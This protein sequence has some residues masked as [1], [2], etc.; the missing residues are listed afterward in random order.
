MT[1]I[2]SRTFLI[3]VVTSSVTFWQGANAIGG[4]LVSWDSASSLINTTNYTGLG[5]YYWFA[6]FNN[7]TPSPTPV[8]LTVGAPLDDH[9]ARNL[10]AWIRVESRSAFIGKDDSGLNSDTTIR[11]GFSFEESANGSSK[12][13]GGQSNFNV[14]TLPDGATGLSGQVF[15]PIP[16]LAT[17]ASMAQ[18][19]ILPGAPTSFRLWVITDNGA[20]ANFQSEARLRVRHA[21]TVGAP[22][23]ATS[24]TE[25]DAEALPS[26]KRLIEAGSDPAANNGIADAWAFRFDDVAADDVITIRPTSASGSFAGF[27]GF[28]IQAVPEPSTALLAVCGLCSL[29]LPANRRMHRER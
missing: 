4:N 20:G 27:S 29:F 11:T 24:G 22:G 23:Y 28:I 13:I 26:G 18:F 10:P 25:V 17:T 6:N 16:G 9:E 2:P 21:A 8:S 15:D 3:A 1:R 5:Q 19:R 12:S 7:P 14:L